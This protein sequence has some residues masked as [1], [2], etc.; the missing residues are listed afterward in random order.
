MK[1][2]TSKALKMLNTAVDT[3]NKLL[4]SKDISLFSHVNGTEL[5]NWDTGKKKL[6]G[7]KCFMINES[8]CFEIGIYHIN[9]EEGA[10]PVLYF[11]DKLEKGNHFIDSTN[12]QSNIEGIVTK[13]IESALKG[14]QN[15]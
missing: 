8:F 7:I 13:I 9:D 3:A 5:T 15:A 12:K 1:S 10:K 4:L 2:N 14:K 6:I 11:T